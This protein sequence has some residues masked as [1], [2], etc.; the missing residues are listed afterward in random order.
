[1]ALALF[2]ATATGGDTLLDAR[3][4]AVEPHLRIG[5]AVEFPRDRILGVRRAQ[6]VG[7][8]ILRFV[9]W[10]IAEELDPCIAVAVARVVGDAV[11]D[12]EMIVGRIDATSDQLHGIARAEPDMQQTPI[13]R[14]VAKGADAQA[15]DRQAVLVGEQASDRLANT[16][17]TP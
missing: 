8:I 1:L 7:R 9:L 14:L 2:P 15:G 16:L 6:D 10:P 12:D 5:A 13:G 17:L 4:V 3:K 11:E